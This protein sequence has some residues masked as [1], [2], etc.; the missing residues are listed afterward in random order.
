MCDESK[1]AGAMAPKNAK[2]G[3]YHAFLG[4][5]RTLPAANTLMWISKEGVG[6]SFEIDGWKEACCGA[7]I[8]AKVLIYL[9]RHAKSCG[10]QASRFNCLGLRARPDGRQAGQDRTPRESPHPGDTTVRKTPG[11]DWLGGINGDFRVSDKECRR[12]AFALR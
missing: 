8:L 5:D 2:Y 10:Q 6:N 1:V 4:I 12:H 3:P 11:R 9:D 7:V